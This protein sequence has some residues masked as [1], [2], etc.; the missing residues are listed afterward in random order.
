MKLEQIMTQS[1]MNLEQNMTQ[2]IMN[3]EQNMTQSITKLEQNMTHLTN[4]DHS[5]SQ[6]DVCCLSFSDSIFKFTEDN[7]CLGVTSCNEM[8]NYAV[9]TQQM[10]PNVIVTITDSLKLLQHKRSL[11]VVTQLSKR[12]LLQ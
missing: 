3:L 4:H 9:R 2:S 8:T 12:R 7:L 11:H 10:T 6:T 1:I 5:E